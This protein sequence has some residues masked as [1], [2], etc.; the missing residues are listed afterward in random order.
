M[1]SIPIKIEVVSVGYATVTNHFSTAFSPFFPTI[2]KYT[3][4][5]YLNPYDLKIHKNVLQCFRNKLVS[6][7]RIAR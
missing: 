6:D 5:S 3:Y 1:S 4:I 7:R 2:Y